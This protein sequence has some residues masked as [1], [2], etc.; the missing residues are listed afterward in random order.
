MAKKAMIDKE[1]KREKLVAAGKFRSLQ[2]L[3]KKNGTPRFIT[4]RN[5]SKLVVCFAEISN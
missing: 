2:N 5:K 1:A 4:W 3:F